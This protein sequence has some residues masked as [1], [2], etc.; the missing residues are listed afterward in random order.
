VLL[1]FR[2]SA[3][4]H[5]LSSGDTQ[6]DIDGAFTPKVTHFVFDPLVRDER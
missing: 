1:C 6:V 3:D 5:F 4:K 2:G